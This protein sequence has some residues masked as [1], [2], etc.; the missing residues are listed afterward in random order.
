M[1][2]ECENV[3]CWDGVMEVELVSEWF[4]YY[5]DVVWVMEGIIC[6]EMCVGGLIVQQVEDWDWEV[7]LWVECCIEMEQCVYF[8]VYL[9]LFVCLSDVIDWFEFYRE[10]IID[11]VCVSEIISEVDCI[12]EEIGRAHV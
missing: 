11:V 1:L 2:L 4:Y 3:L 6:Q 7:V 8:E 10:I 5:W 9:D 12:M